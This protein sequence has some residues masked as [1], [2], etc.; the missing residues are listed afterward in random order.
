MDF[1]ARRAGGVIHAWPVDHQLRRGDNDRFAAGRAIDFGAGPG[2]IDSQ[3]LF[4][5]RTIK[6]DIHNA[7][8]SFAD[9]SGRIYGGR[10]KANQ[11]VRPVNNQS[12]ATDRPVYS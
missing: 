11:K 7:G 12:P 5:L 10:A 2:A 3:L 9:L 8:L 6:D 4:A 1:H